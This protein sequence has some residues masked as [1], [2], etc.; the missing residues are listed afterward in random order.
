MIDIWMVFY[1]VLAA[2]ISTVLYVLINRPFF[3]K[4]QTIM[5]PLWAIIL[6][7]YVI[8]INP[9]YETGFF[10]SQTSSFYSFWFHLLSSY[11]CHI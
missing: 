11:P 4:I 9:Q 10:S 7:I 8:I 2:I 6:A 1:A 5:L 3:Q